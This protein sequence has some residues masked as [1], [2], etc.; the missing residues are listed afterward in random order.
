MEINIS[1]RLS[2]KKLPL[3]YRPTFVSLLKAVLCTHYPVAYAEMYENSNIQ[4]DFTFAI[5]FCNP[6]FGEQEL[7]VS[8][9]NIDF[10]LS[11]NNDYLSMLFYNAFQKSVDYCHPLG[12]HAT[13]SVASVAVKAQPPITGNSVTVKFLSPLVVRQHTPGAADRYYIYSD[14]AFCDC[15]RFVV[16]R[17]L[18]RAVDL[19]LEPVAPQKTVVCSFGVKIRCSLGTYRI[20]AEPEILDKLSKSGIGSRRG[21]GYGYFKVVG[22]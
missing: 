19:R 14:P 11:S 21:E 17:Q 5:R 1:L 4:K 15:L 7:S 8:N 12:N 3:D 9:E 10:S 13:M 16:E 20:C 22:G 18:G 2:Q 6:V